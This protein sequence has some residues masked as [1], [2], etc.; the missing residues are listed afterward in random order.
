M[1]LTLHHTK[2][3]ACGALLNMSHVKEL[4]P[5]LLEDK[6]PDVVG[7]FLNS[8]A[9]R[10]VD[11]ARGVLLNLAALEDDVRTHTSR[12]VLDLT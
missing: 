6:V 5:R 3:R 2:R 9:Q 11:V 1:A 7:A 12:M 8:K 10:V 4:R